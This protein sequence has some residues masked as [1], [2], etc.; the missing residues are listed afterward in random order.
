[1][2]RYEFSDLSILFIVCENEKNNYNFELRHFYDVKRCLT[3]FFDTPE[4]LLTSILSNNCFIKVQ[5]NF[6][7]HQ[8]N[9]FFSNI[10]GSHNHQRSYTNQIINIVNETKK[11]QILR[12]EFLFISKF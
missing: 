9:V 6:Q 3:H 8:R 10:G 1:M 5:Q 12:F 2:C 4:N 11:N 7:A